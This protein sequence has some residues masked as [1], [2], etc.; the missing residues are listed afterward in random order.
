MT[1]SI[2]IV[3]IVGRQNVGKS[4]LLNRVAGQRI[5]ITEDLPGTT[6]DRVFATATWQGRSF[7][8]V[9]TGG[10]EIEP[11]STIAQQVNEQ[12]S[13]A[14]E[15][16]DVLLFL[17]DAKDGL[18]TVDRE[19]ADRLRQAGK[20]VLLVVNKADNQ[21]LEAQ[22]PEFYELGIGEPLI[23]S[24]YH[25]R[26]THEL[27]D[28]VVGMLPPVVEAPVGEGIRVAIVGRANVGK[29][30]LIN[31]LLG[32]QRAIVSNIPGTTRDATDTPIDFNGS[33][34]TLIDTAG[35]RRRGKVERGIENYSVLR[36]LKAIDRADVVL[37]VLDATELVTA[38]DTHIAGY[39]NQATRGMIIVINKWDMASNLNKK[40]VGSI[41][42]DRFKF[43]AYAPV[44]YI[45]AKEG[46]GVEKILPKV[47]QIDEERQKRIATA[48]V[49]STVRA[50]LAEHTPPRKG[51]KRLNVLYATQ[52]EVNPPAFVFFVNDATLMHFSYER[53]LENKLRQAYGFDGTPIK[54]VFK[55]R[56]EQE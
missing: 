24:A 19:I 2:P 7:T 45:S 42:Q 39:I 27:L 31:R 32:Q 15:E 47:C 14:I 26:G 36:A 33:P 41:I 13:S 25:G 20:E 38:Q 48:A 43:M 30:T 3:A 8:I 5:A 17:V 52:A 40:E 35:I 23:T 44:L 56:G 6:R 16:A 21:R 50:A 55:T 29:S 53:Y 51:K 11:T 54:L 4:T 1:T 28:K 18:T 22:A 9:D 49:N 37:L 34:M 46:Q 12:V 10:L